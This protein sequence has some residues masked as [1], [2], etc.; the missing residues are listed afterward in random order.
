MLEKQQM[1]IQKV[2][3]GFIVV[4]PVGGQGGKAI[5]CT[6]IDEACDIVKKESAE[7]IANAETKEEAPAN[8]ETS[9]ESTQSQE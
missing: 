5:V 6:T 7:I 4:S 8:E 9:E 2:S 1:I 3:N